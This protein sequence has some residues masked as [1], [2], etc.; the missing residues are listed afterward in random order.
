MSVFHT[1]SPVLC[2]EYNL[3]CKKIPAFPFLAWH[4]AGTTL[5]CVLGIWEEVMCSASAEYAELDCCG[6][7]SPGEREAL[8]TG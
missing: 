3:Q 8:G 6:A 7:A 2:C 1:G 5:T 4:R